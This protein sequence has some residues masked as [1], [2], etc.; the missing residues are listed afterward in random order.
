MDLNS[1][2]QNSVKGMENTKQFERRQPCGFNNTIYGFNNTK[3]GSREITFLTKKHRVSNNNV[4][5]THKHS[6]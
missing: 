6:K 2:I 3:Y 5:T 1:H 4:F